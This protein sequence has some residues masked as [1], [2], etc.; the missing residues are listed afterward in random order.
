MEITLPSLHPN[1]TRP[2]LTEGVEGMAAGAWN[3]HCNRPL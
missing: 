2:E 3:L 1:S